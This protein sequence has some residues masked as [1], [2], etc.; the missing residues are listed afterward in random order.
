MDLDWLA[1]AGLLGC[2][3]VMG[4]INNLAGAAGVLGLMGLQ[5]FAGLDDLHANASLRPAAVA[6]GLSGWLGFRSRGMSIPRRA[7]VFGLLSIPGAVLGAHMALTLPQWVYRTTLLVILSTVLVQQLRP[8]RI[9][10]VPRRVSGPVAAVAFVLVGAHMGFIQ[11]AAG[12]FTMAVLTATHSRDLVHVNAAK[13]AI[14]ICSSVAAVAS[15][16]SAESVVWQPAIVL[17]ASC[18][19]GSFWAS[20]WSMTRG[21]AA[22]RVVVLVITITALLRFTWQ[23]LA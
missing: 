1:T 16:G 2:G 22:V 9:D 10:A 8:A 14:V 13:M 11:I 4:A 20:R 12:L 15:F 19:L 7:W 18:G 21:H 17:A 23:M 5:D 6:I 3:L